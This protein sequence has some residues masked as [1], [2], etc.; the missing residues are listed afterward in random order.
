[1]DAEYEATFFVRKLVE[2]AIHR[3][4]FR[5]TLVELIETNMGEL[6]N[7]A[8]P[9]DQ[10][11]PG[12]VTLPTERLVPRHDA[13]P[14]NELASRIVVGCR[15]ERVELAPALECGLLQHIVNP[16]R[17]REERADES[18]DR[19]IVSGEQADEFTVTLLAIGGRFGMGLRF[20]L[21]GVPGV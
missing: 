13:G 9:E 1:M 14:A 3:L 15:R 18:P 17:R 19:L 6:F 16:F 21:H 5:L 12:P 8:L 7:H 20:W 2:A 11:V 4:T 10:S